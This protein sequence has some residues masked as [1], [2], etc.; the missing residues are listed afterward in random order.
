MG[1]L[2]DYIKC[3]KFIVRSELDYHWG[4]M[5]LNISQSEFVDKTIDCIFDS[6]EKI[7]ENIDRIDT[8]T[9]S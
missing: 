4:N 1:K 9:K 5:N 7:A 2:M 6:L 3:Q 8:G